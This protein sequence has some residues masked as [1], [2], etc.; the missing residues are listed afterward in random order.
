METTT[1]L[2][3][4]ATSEKKET[5]LRAVMERDRSFD[6]S[7]VFGVGSTRIYCRPSCPSRR[8]RAEKIL[9]FPNPESAEESGFR[10]CLRCKPRLAAERAGLVG[11]I[12]THI[13]ANLTGDVSLSALGKEFDMS[14]YHLQRVFKE[15][16]G[17][18][19]RRYTEECR[20]NKLKSHLAKGHSVTSALRKS[21]YRSQSW[22][23]TDSTSKLGMTPGVF[24]RGGV[25]MRIAYHTGGSP[26]GRLLVASTEHGICMVHLGESDEELVRTL[27]R[28]YPKAII[29]ESSDS[30][31]YFDSV[32]GYF[33]GQLKKLPLD[34]RGTEFQRRV[35]TALQTIPE[36]SVCSY[37]DVAALIGQ[38]RA[39]RAVANACGKNPVPLIVPCHRVVRKDGGLGGYG[40]GIWRKKALLAEESR[41]S[42]GVG[43]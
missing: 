21:G 1:T 43:G 4:R 36:G 29:E 23:Y 38:P 31:R 3:I 11:R 17:M 18:S 5:L 20:I 41:R 26:L 35:W 8:P 19:P 9:L 39:V 28:E 6:G 33:S 37:S 13:Q 27:H 22:L 15:V 40:L 42:K 30:G 14:P 25:G 12:C 7:F 16:V 2:G 34:L 10:Q 32:L 24:R